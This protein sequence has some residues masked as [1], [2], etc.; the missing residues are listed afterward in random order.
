MD[1]SGTLE[2]IFGPMRSG[3]TTE[4]RRRLGIFASLGFK[5]TCA[6][7]ERDIRPGSGFSTHNKELC[8]DSQNIFPQKVKKVKN[9]DIEGFDVV[10]I[11]EAQFFLEKTLVED[12]MKIVNAGKVVIMSGLDGD[13]DQEEMGDYL[14]LIPK[15]DKAEKMLAWCYFCAQGKRMKRAPFSKRL[16][17]NDEKILVGNMYASVCRECLKN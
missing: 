16:V 17:E 1:V 12:V 15:A 10:G 6:N 9:I 11:D 2:M 13:S 5:V 7:S 8:E 3:K 4:L 14:K